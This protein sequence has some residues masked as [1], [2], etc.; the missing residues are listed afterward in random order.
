MNKAIVIKTK[1]DLKISSLK[2][3]EVHRFHIHMSDNALGVPWRVPVVIIRGIGKGPVFGITAAVHGDE[4]NGIS[5]IFKL[6]DEINPM[7]LNG[8]LVLVPISNIPGYLENQRYFSDH[9]DLN[10]IMPG[11]PVGT[12]SSVYCHESGY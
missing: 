6:I 1:D 2:K 9:T 10:R 3:G 11:S 8:T 4:L 5:T 7:K 12:P